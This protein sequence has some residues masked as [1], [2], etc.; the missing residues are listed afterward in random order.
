MKR[1]V[2]GGLFVFSMFLAAS[3]S[4]SVSPCCQQAMIECQNACGAGGNDMCSFSCH[5]DCSYSCTCR[6][7]CLPNIENS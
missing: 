1:L 2:L 5:S 3:A 6:L 7:A 4:S